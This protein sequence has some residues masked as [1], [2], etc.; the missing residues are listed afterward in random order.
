MVV[1]VN[2]ERMDVAATSVRALLAEL[3][4][5]GSF[6]AVAVDHDVIPKSRWDEDMIGQGAAIEIVTPRQGG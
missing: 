4:H 6:Y 1:T 3:G 5:E 2:G